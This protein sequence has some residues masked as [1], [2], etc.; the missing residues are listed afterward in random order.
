MEKKQVG[1]FGYL[2]YIKKKNIL[3][4]V[5]AFAVVFAVLIAGIIIFKTKTNY[6]TVL[7]VVLVL[8][9]AKMAVACYI[10][11][12]HKGCDE[13]THNEVLAEAGKLTSLFDCIVS[14]SKKPI[15]VS[16]VVV[17]D[18][19]ICA[20]TTEKADKNLFETSVTEFLKAD[21]L[22]VNV[23]LYDNKEQFLNRIRKMATNFDMDN[24]HLADKMEWNTKTFLNMCI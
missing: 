6:M 23:T 9:A 19:C 2:D 4:T 16:A 12:T 5:I 11:V 18:S 14:N 1:E 13:A 24:K 17:T 10:A 3:K 7:S 20:Y 21:K 15:G 8:P 22:N